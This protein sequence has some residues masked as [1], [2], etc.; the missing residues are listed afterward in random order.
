MTAAGYERIRRWFLARPGWLAALRGANRWLPRLLYTAYPLVLLALAWR[1]DARLWPV[2]AVPAAGFA[3]VS[4]FRRL[5][6]APRPYEA[7]AI[8][9]LVPRGK[10][11]RSFPSRHVASAFLIGCAG[12]YLTPWLGLP[13]F[14]AGAALAVI[15][16]LA[17]VHFPRD[18]AA[19]AAFGLLF[20]FLCLCGLPF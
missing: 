17:G 8:T 10:A 3:L 5:Y 4:L 15:R 1:R 13:A 9:P 20:G 6:N 7:L 14:L 19:G 11:G 16:P 2:L 12:W 18:T